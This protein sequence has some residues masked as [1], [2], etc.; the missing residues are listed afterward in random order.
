MNLIRTAPL[1]RPWKLNHN[2]P[3][4]L[5]AVVV[6]MLARHQE[7]RYLNPAALLTDLERLS[8]RG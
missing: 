7:D 5:D 1:V 6:R 2:I 3:V 8:E 4:E